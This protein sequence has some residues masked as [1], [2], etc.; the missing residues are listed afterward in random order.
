MAKKDIEEPKGRNQR[1]DNLKKRAVMELLKQKGYNLSETAKESGV[2]R[3]TLARWIKGNEIVTKEGSKILA[4]DVIDNKLQTTTE[5]IFKTISQSDI[6]KGLACLSD[7]M[8]T[9]MV[10][11]DKVLK[12]MLILVENEN[13]LP[14]LSYVLTAISKYLE[15]VEGANKTPEKQMAN[16]INNIQANF[17]ANE[18]MMTDIANRLI[19]LKQQ[20]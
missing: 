5:K 12:R 6:D 15:P 18:E 20:K 3:K 10:L 16:T 4:R 11:R 19:E 2:H 14:N 17:T 9:S 7:Y 13:S 1:I 8:A